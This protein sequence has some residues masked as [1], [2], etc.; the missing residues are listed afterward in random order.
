MADRLGWIRSGQHGVHLWTTRVSEHEAHEEPVALT[1]GK[2][3]G[4][5]G[6]ERILGG[7]HEEG[8]GQRASDAVHAHLALLHR[9]E[10]C[11]LGPRRGPV[12]LV[13]H[14]D[15][16]EHR[17][18]PK[19]GFAPVGTEHGGSYHVA[20]QQVRRALETMELESQCAG[21][22]L[23]QGGLAEP[24]MVLHQEMATSCQAGD[25]QPDGGRCG[26]HN[27]GHRFFRAA[28]VAVATVSACRT[29]TC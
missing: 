21:Q 17:S 27:G 18:G 4:A 1:V 14:E 20:G 19:P 25:R 12:E 5:R 3:R 10:E 11:G 22:S 23:G 29:D 26:G 16:G 7:E 28:N 13:G 15:V 24:W 9:L 2:R 8:F 6:V